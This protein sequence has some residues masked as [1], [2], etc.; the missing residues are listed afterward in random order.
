MIQRTAPTTDVKRSESKLATDNYSRLLAIL[1]RNA[2]EVHE[3]ELARRLR[4]AI[5]GMEE[6]RG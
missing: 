4:D 1:E 6:R 5:R 3:P 2:A